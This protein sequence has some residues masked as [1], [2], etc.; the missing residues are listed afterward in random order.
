MAEGLI[1][2]LAQLLPVDALNVSRCVCVRL[3]EE[4][5]EAYSSEEV[6]KGASET[7]EKLVSRTVS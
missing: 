2:L 1:P 4:Q 5:I 6:F 3:Y 7:V